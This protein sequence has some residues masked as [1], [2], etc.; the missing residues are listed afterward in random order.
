MEGYQPAELYGGAIRSVVPSTF[1]D[2]SRVKE[3]GDFQEMF[4]DRET[5][6]LLSF[7][8]FERHGVSDIAAGE[9][10]FHELAETN[11]ASGEHCVVQST[12]PIP[13]EQCP[14]LAPKFPVI[15]VEGVQHIERK[16]ESRSPVR[17][18][19]VVVRLESVG[20][21]FVVSISSPVVGDA[22]LEG[23]EGRDAMQKAIHALT[24]VD[25]GLFGAE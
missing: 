14:S 11:D 16:H 23:D 1:F 15:W 20:T 21:D 12:R 18:H 13:T 3:I 7:E 10:F 25:W 2:L 6:S 19:L 4:L 5:G 9:F 24:V 22:T 8:V 17:V